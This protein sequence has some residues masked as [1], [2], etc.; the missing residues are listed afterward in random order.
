MVSGSNRSGGERKDNTA[1]IQSTGL[2]MG[3]HGGG[4][5][6]ESNMQSPCLPAGII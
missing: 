1:V 3:L 4:G 5:I 6:D 2:E